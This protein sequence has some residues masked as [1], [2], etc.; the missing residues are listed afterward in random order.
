[1]QSKPV[2]DRL[3]ELVCVICGRVV[4]AK[5]SYV[6]HSYVVAK[7]DPPEVVGG[8]PQLSTLPPVKARMHVGC[9]SVVQDQIPNFLGA[10]Y[11]RIADAVRRGDVE[12]PDGEGGGPR[13]IMP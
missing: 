12:F 8:S 9:S 6:D 2:P 11:G 1:M 4:D 7:V 3:P 5:Q 10:V 13:I